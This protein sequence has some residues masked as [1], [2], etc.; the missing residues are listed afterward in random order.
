MCDRV[1]L[2]KL[3]LTSQQWCGGR[4]EEVD[5]PACMFSRGTMDGG[6]GSMQYSATEQTAQTAAATHQWWMPCRVLLQ[7]TAHCSLLTAQGSRRRRS[8]PSFF[9]SSPSASLIT[10][11]LC[12]FFF[13]GFCICIREGIFGILIYRLL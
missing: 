4:T 13:G 11:I 10:F 7:L 9:S 6:H 8:H 5:R 2:L 1:I 3:L 12:P